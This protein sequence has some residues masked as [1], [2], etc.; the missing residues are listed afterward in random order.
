MSAVVCR[1]QVT[2]G[3]CDSAVLLV[4]VLS[5]GKILD[6][7]QKYSEVSVWG[8]VR[9]ICSLMVNICTASTTIPRSAHTIYL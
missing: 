8:A 6:I 3:A 7:F 2:G 1:D 5:G 9:V 4:C